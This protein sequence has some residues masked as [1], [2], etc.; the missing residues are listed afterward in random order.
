M[1]DRG[2]TIVGGRISNFLLEKSRVVSVAQNE[3]NF[4][5][6]HQLIAGADTATK[7]NLGISSADYYNYLSNANQ[8]TEAIDD[9]R[10]FDETLVGF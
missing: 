9:V 10:E 1:F 2:G 6:F 7:R 8:K 3:R 5:I 4:H